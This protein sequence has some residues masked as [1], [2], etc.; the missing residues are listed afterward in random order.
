MSGS[1]TLRAPPEA[2]SVVTFALCGMAAVGAATVSAAR[3][4][5]GTVP[6]QVQAP[7]VSDVLG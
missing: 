3:G 1:P 2:L 7:T 5:G 6:A 4:G